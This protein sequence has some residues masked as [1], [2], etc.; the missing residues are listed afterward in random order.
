M[1]VH[2]RELY[3]IDEISPNYIYI[4]GTCAS[5]KSSPQ[6]EVRICRSG[7]VKSYGVTKRGLTLFTIDRSTLTVTGITTFDVYASNTPTYDLRVTLDSLS[8]DV[9]AVLV[10][11]DAIGWTDMSIEGLKACGGSTPRFTSRGTYPFAFIGY[12]GLEEGCGQQIMGTAGSSVPAEISVYVANRMFTTSKD[13]AQGEP[14]KPAT[15]YYTWMKF[16]DSLEADGYPSYCY[17]T[18]TDN[19]NYIGLAYNQTSAS[20][21]SDPTK[22][23]WVSTG[24]DGKDGTSFSIK[25]G[26]A[27]HYDNFENAQAGLL[28]LGVSDIFAL[29]DDM[30][31]YDSGLSGAGALYYYRYK[32]SAYWSDAEA[33][34]GDAY[35]DTDKNVWVKDNSAWVNLGTIQ[36][37]KGE[38]GNPGPP[39]PQGQ[40]GPIVYPAGEWSADKTYTKDSF[41]TPMVYHNGSKWVLNVSSNKGTEPSASNSDIWRVMNAW[42][43]LFTEILFSEF[44]KLGASIF[45][46]DYQFSQWG[47]LNGI[48]STEYQNFK[49]GNSDNKF[50]PNYYINFLTGESWLQKAHVTGEINATS[51]VFTNVKIDGTLGAPF[52]DLIKFTDFDGTLDEWRVANI[53]RVKEHDN[54]IVYDGDNI[55]Y[56][57]GTVRDCGRTL[58][59]MAKNNDVVISC[60]GSEKRFLDN[61]VLVKS[62]TIKRGQLIILKGIGNNSEFQYYLVL[63][64]TVG[65]L[66]HYA[67]SLPGIRDFV[68]LRGRVNISSISSPVYMAVSGIKCYVNRNADGVFTVSWT[69]GQLVGSVDNIYVNIT[70]VASIAYTPVL[71]NISQSSFQV[72]FYHYNVLGQTNLTGFFFSV[73]IID[74]NI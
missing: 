8:A 27:Y 1:I 70:P 33:A 49:P 74:N 50:L 10:S 22:Y 31:S 6:A 39:G 53:E 16:A 44:A 51:G 2:S 36:G 65:Y 43:N 62:V 63:F 68:F 40:I 55:H 19:T 21:S 13:G 25:Q 46:G 38:Q 57:S 54:S 45:S 69:A 9:F 32:G 12:R 60:E 72:R 58:S 73:K 17:D 47:K 5:G 41:S 67:G 34:I 28:S 35:L 15:Q 42:Q 3:V 23:K 30:S 11:Y 24:L 20:E 71:V 14:G 18:P 61:G 4:K 66:G 29:I 48:E 52:S 37:P 56:L 64:K 26:T 7:D 59:I